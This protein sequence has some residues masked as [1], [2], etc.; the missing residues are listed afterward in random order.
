VPTNG[1]IQVSE[2]RFDNPAPIPERIELRGVTVEFTA[3]G[4]KVPLTA[5]A[6]FPDGSTLDVT[7]G[8]LGTNYTTSNSQVVT[9]DAEGQVTAI[10]SG[11]AILSASH[12]G[13]IGFLQVSVVASADSDGDGLPDDFEITNG[14]DP[15]DPADALEDPDSD[16]LTTLAE[17]L[18]GLDPFDSDTDKDGLLDGQEVNTTGT[19]PLLF[20]T[21]GDGLGDGL[22][23]QTGSDPLDPTSFN[24]GAALVSLRVEPS[25]V[26]LVFNTVFGEAS[27]Q[28]T[29]SGDLI[30]GNSLDLTAPRFGTTYRSSDLTI[31]SF[32]AEPGRV[33]AGQGGVATVTAEVAGFSTEAVVTVESQVSEALSFLRLP[34]FPNSVAVQGDYAYVASG[35]A[36]LLVVDVTNLEAPFLAASLPLSGNANDVVLEGGFAYVAGGT[37]GVHV[38]EITNPT[39][40]VWRGTA[41]PVV[42]ATDLAV[43]AD[44]LFV[45]DQQGLALFDVFDPEAPVLLGRVDLPGESRGVAVAGDLAV[46]AANLGGVHVVDVSEAS[47]PVPQGSIHTRSGGVSHAADVAV[48]DGIAWVADG[49]GET[50]GGLRRVFL[51]GLKAIDLSR[52][53]TPVVVGSTTDTLGLMDVA[54]ERSFALGADFFFLNGVPILDVADVSPILRGELDFSGPPSFRADNGNGIAVRDGVVFLVA[55]RVLGLDNGRWGDGALHIGRYARFVDDS[56]V[57]P[58]VALL[59]PEVGTVTRERKRLVLEATA[60]DDV[61]VDRVEFLLDGAVV[62]TDYDAPF[63]QSLAVPVGVSRLAVQAVAWDRGTNQASTETVLLS[64]LPNRAPEVDLLTPRSGATVIEGETIPV[65]VAATDDEAVTR[66]EVFLDGE[67]IAAFTSP[68]YRLNLTAVSPPPANP[69]TLE[70]MAFDQEG[71]VTRSSEVT[72]TVMPDPAPAVEILEPALGPVSEGTTLR[73]VIGVDDNNPVTAVELMVDG[74]SVPPRLAPPFVFEVLVPVGA[75]E[76][77]LQAVAEDSRGQRTTTTEQLFAV[78]TDPP[79]VRL[80]SPSA[81][82]VLVAGQG[83]T[84][85]AVVADDVGVQE[86]LFLVDDSEVAALDTAPYRVPFTVPSGVT[87]LSLEAVAIDTAGLAA[88]AQRSFVVV[89]DQ[90]PTVRLISPV[91]GAT[92]IEGSTVLL[93]A[94]ASDEGAVASVTFRLNGADHA[95]LITP[96]YESSLTVPVGVASVTLEAIA[97]DDGGQ[98]A[99]D[100][101][102]FPVALNQP[103][104]VTLLTPE[105]GA[106]LV[107]GGVAP[108]LAEVTDDVGIAVVEFVV[109]DYFGPGNDRVETVFS[110]PWGFSLA[111]PTGLDPLTLEVTATDLLGLTATTTRSWSVVADAPTTVVGVVVDALAMP[112]PGA[113]VM[114]QGDLGA[115]L[116]DAQG[117]FSIPAVTSGQGDLRALVTAAVGDPE[118][119]FLSGVSTAQPP[120]AGGITD[121]GVTT[122]VPPNEFV[123]SDLCSDT[124]RP[125]R[126]RNF[127]SGEPCLPGSPILSSPEDVTGVRATVGGSEV[128]LTFDFGGDITPELLSAVISLD[129][130]EEPGTGGRSAVDGLSSHPATD[131][132]TELEI[133]IVAGETE[134]VADGVGLQ[135]GAHSMTVVFPLS[136]LGDGQ[137]RFAAGFFGYGFG[138]GS[139]LRQVEDPGLRNHPDAFFENLLDVDVIPNGGSLRVPGAPDLDGDGALDVDEVV[140]GTDPLAADTDQDFLLDGFELLYGFDPRTDSGEAF[141][142]PDGDGLETAQ[143][144]VLGSDPFAS[145]SDLDGLPDSDELDVHGTLPARADS[146]GDG[147]D[148]GE[149]FFQTGTDPALFDSDFDG[150]GDGEE[151]SGPTSSTNFDS[152]AGGASD[153]L[154]VWLD[155]TDPTNAT[156]DLSTVLLGDGTGNPSDTALAMDGAGSVHLAWIQGGFGSRWVYYSLVGADGQVRIAATPLGTTFSAAQPKLAV[157]SQGRIHLV[158]EGTADL[159]ARQEIYHSLI[160]PA[161]DDQDGSPADPAQITLVDDQQISLG[162]GIDGRSPRLALD[163]LDR[164]HV[165]WVDLFATEE[166]HYAR[167]NAAGAVDL[168]DRL[169][170]TDLVSLAEDGLV[171]DL[172]LTVDS[173]HGVHLAWTDESLDVFSRSLAYALVDGESGSLSIDATELLPAAEPHFLRQATLLPGSDGRVRLIYL[174]ELFFSTAEIRAMELDSTLDDRNGDTANPAQIV[175]QDHRRMHSLFGGEFFVPTAANNPDGDLFLTYLSTP[176]GGDTQVY[177][178]RFDATGLQVLPPLRVSGSSACSFDR[179]SVA[180][181][182]TVGFVA[183]INCLEDRV[184]VR[185][186]LVGGGLGNP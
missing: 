102:S 100:G 6:R 39:T 118:V 138:F 186:F 139:F 98:T 153:G 70:A 143:E 141:D 55:T 145:D 95:T 113:A 177:L 71:Q 33:F 57:P 97:E 67:I 156:D 128:S 112:V 92:L 72:L 174:R 79:S 122:L 48:R 172:T 11:V 73:V 119:G 27:R 146:D 14:L 105:E 162:G 7:S 168:P 21:D 160:A 109:P 157:D 41:L 44:R 129:L 124:T 76:L 82:T 15:N 53:E 137:F 115:V 77:R 42:E 123:Y 78:R 89:A 36:G 68:P 106:L 107:A 116:S 142:D 108:V 29:V 101:G 176:V 121:L 184:E 178:T 35:Q 125:S 152:D 46:V 74:T 51:G 149:E 16:G 117:M 20:D 8:T 50:G 127:G 161:L 22:E 84:L 2:I 52:P 136:L 62:A 111:V 86:V 147:L 165:V 17:F 38:V 69:I 63:L 40:P 30:D 49:A 25:A 158:W 66:V 58:A 83:I 56:G 130:D 148:D 151:E 61:A 45:A 13:V 104:T 19:A 43:Q 47:M 135:F 23:I 34:G 179:P 154:E 133:L 103:P 144:M 65:V 120:V 169:L 59:R 80:T 171:D 32:G 60:T 140:A 9:V 180:V 1:V 155:G 150:L 28:L 93:A 126:P 75:V 163:A 183:W 185:E 10:G 87:G 96:P 94:E 31:A 54:L 81:G 181:R 170:V 114:L 88:T 4:Q 164:A 12:E 64:V 24:L 85:E 18:A 173:T 131:L 37:A 99:T 167:L 132:G 110:P 166:L 90:A 134:A 26:T 3:V 5:T 91:P 159:D 182:G 175:L